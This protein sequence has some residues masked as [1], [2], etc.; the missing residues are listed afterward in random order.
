M[1]PIAKPIIGEEEKRAVL[2]VLNSGMLAQGKK[3][4]EFETNFANYVGVK[5]AIATSNGTTALHAAL[6]AHGIGPDDEVITT[7]FTFIAT[8]NAIKMVGAKPVFVDI[9]EDSLN[10]NPDLIEAVITA[11]TK[12]IL[13][14]HLFGLPADMKKIQ[15]SADKHNLII[16]EDACQAHG[17]A[18]DGQKVGSFGTGC[19]SF[20]PT[21]NIT[22]G[23]GGIITTNDSALA[24]K[25]KK[26]I[27]H[28][29]EKKYYHD[30]LGYN[31]RMTD[32]AAAIGI[33]QL[34]KINQFNQK[35]KENAILLNKILK[36]KQGIVLPL[37]NEG[38]SLHQYTIRI[39]PELGKTREEI[40]EI[41]K[42]TGIDSSVFYPL[43]VHK[44]KSFAE[45]N[46]LTLPVAEK[47]AQQVL[48]LPINPSVTTEEIELIGKTIKELV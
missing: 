45:Y 33:E 19:F 42:Q 46:H 12:A 24:N 11:K 40:I 13:P 17:A 37:I 31:F 28:G 22:T 44:Q 14:V 15:E 18:F 8:A 35:R 43:P 6:L 2:E 4:T 7:P 29:S 38:H 3:V 39:L 9:E 23:E 20:Y 47:V 36:D 26:I 1:I 16:I 34:K 27:N 10:L 5:H 41:L 48:S 30:C 32:I 21:K 25:I